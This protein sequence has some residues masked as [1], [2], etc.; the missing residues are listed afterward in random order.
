M[1]I[2][3]NATSR[4]SRYIASF[5]PLHARAVGT[6]VHVSPPA[7]SVLLLDT[8][9]KSRS[10]DRWPTL[11]PCYGAGICDRPTQAGSNPLDRNGLSLLSLGTLSFMSGRLP[12][13]Y[14]F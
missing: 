5:N 9:K 6:P 11:T 2:S 3:S 10:T 13:L 7:L 12:P 8:Y 4:H 14:T 1:L